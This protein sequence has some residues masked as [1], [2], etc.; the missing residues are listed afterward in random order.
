MSDAPPSSHV[1]EVTDD[2]AGEFAERVVEA[3]HYRPDE[4]FPLAV[5]GGPV[6][7]ECYERLASHGET[8]IDWWNVELFWADECRVPP[9]HEDSHERLA[10]DIL[11][12]RVGAAFAVHPLRDE[13]SLQEAAAALATRHLDVVHLDLGADGRLSS[14]FPGAAFSG[15]FAATRDPAGVVPHER[16]SLGYDAI[17]QAGAVF[18]TA[19]GQAVRSALAAVRAGADVPGNRLRC[20]RVTWLA[21]RAAGLA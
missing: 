1:V 14:L 3:F 15:A 4:R 21:D 2:V 17:D 5:C 20:P 8:Q 18:I 13:A 9:D 19:I 10:R 16:Y 6:A 11:L 12:D 7:A